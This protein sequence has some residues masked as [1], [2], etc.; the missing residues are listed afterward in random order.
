MRRSIGLAALLLLT[1]CPDPKPSGG[2]T[3]VHCSWTDAT[4]SQVTGTFAPADLTAIQTDCATSGGAYAAGGC[5]PVGAVEG[6][7]YYADFQAATGVPVAGA[8]M[9][10]YYFPPSWNATTAAADCSGAWLGSDEPNDTLGTAT[11]L[12]LDTQ[13]AASMASASDL[14]FYVF[15]VPAGGLEITF[16]TFDSTGAACT[17]IDPWLDFYDAGGTYLWSADDEGIDWCEDVALTFPAGTYF[18]EVG[19]WYPDTFSYVLT[20]STG[21]VPTGSVASASCY[22]A[23]S[24][25][26]EQYTGRFSSA[27]LATLQNDCGS[28]SFASAACPTANAVSGRCAI[29]AI[30]VGAGTTVDAYLYSPNYTSGTAA[31]ACTGAGYTW[32]N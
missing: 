24:G 30:P 1:A 31:S 29:G 9:I 32:V 20:T 4:C 25:V 27:S 3:S 6:Y 7:C 15:T 13:V 22:R 23:S 17:T 12:V 16:R 18:V 10:D 2:G 21:P 28:G 14:D 5:S 11:P 8:T 19:G 26:C